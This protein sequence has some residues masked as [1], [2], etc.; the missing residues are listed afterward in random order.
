M[1]KALI[2]LFV[3]FIAIFSVYSLDVSLGIFS[4]QWEIPK[5]AGQVISVSYTPFSYKEFDFGL[6]ADVFTGILK[7]EK[8]AGRQPGI[9]IAYAVKVL[10]DFNIQNFSLYSGIG[11]FS[12]T[13][14]LKNGKW[15]LDTEWG[16]KHQFNDNWGF[17]TS[18]GMA[19]NVKEYTNGQVSDVFENKVFTSARLYASYIFN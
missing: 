6:K 8:R 10:T 1:K 12:N 4:S 2:V 17:G 11:L 16:F 7:P 9:H 15:G 19:F 3:L 5:D 18:F 14:D 13:G